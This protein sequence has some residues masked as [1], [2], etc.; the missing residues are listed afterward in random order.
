MKLDKSLARMNWR[1]ALQRIM[2]KTRKTLK[3]VVL[4]IQDD[5][6]KI[7]K[8][9]QYFD[10]VGA[11]FTRLGV[12]CTLTD[13]MSELVHRLHGKA[14]KC[15]SIE[16]AVQL[17]LKCK[18]KPAKRLCF[19]IDNCNYLTPDHLFYLL[20]LIIEFEHRFQFLFV[21]RKDNLQRWKTRNSKDRR[22]RFFLNNIPLR[23][24]LY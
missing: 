9:R 16:T 14:Q 7:S 10:S 2:R 17:L 18:T 15:K 11:T 12:T 8:M 5:P 22:V 24:E 19:V 4:V 23:Y 3:P 21:F 6:T 20:G 1:I 13:V